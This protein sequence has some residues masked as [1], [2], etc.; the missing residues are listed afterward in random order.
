[1]SLSEEHN[2]SAGQFFSEA[3]LLRGWRRPLS[4]ERRQEA[5]DSNTGC[6]R[7]SVPGFTG[8]PRYPSQTKVG[9]REAARDNTGVLRPSVLRT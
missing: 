4:S 3:Q 7:N 1:M 6:V 8:A 9:G 2:H 5:N